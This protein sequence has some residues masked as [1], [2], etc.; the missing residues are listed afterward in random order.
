MVERYYRDHFVKAGFIILMMFIL[1]AAATA[2][3]WNELNRMSEQ[4]LTEKILDFQKRLDQNPEDYEMLKA[5]GIAFHARAGKDAKKFAPR[6][7]EML[8]RASEIDKKDYETQCYLGSATTMLA[9]T[10]WNPMKK[11]SYA[12][13]GI[14]MMDKAVR[15]APDNVS[16]RLTRAYNS[17][18]LPHFFGREETA[19]EDFEYLAEMIEKNPDAYGSLKEDVYMNLVELYRKNDNKMKA[20]KYQKMLEG[21]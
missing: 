8:T 5:V 4:E 21:R 18:R 9:K 15:K 19:I 14:A 12:N 13:K 2:K 10:T 11:M 20:E 17:R 1:A 7:F 16:V 3:D 6:A